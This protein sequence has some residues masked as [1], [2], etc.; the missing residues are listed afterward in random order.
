MKIQKC[1][2]VFCVE[3]KEADDHYNLTKSIKMFTPGSILKSK[4]NEKSDYRGDSIVIAMI[5][6]CNHRWNII[7]SF[8]KGNT[9]INTKICED[10]EVKVKTKQEEYL[11]YLNSE[12]WKKKAARKRKS[13]D[14][15]CQLCNNGKKT[16]HV[17]HRSYENV[18]HE[19]MRD[20]IVLCEDCH[21]R[22][23]S[24]T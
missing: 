11:D 21:N 7:F 13:A 3:H 8:H 6:E 15:K 23:H 20:L 24:T 18:Y 5:G 22:F 16:L 19:R 10:A 1:S 12:K 2:K 14:N 9:Y 4:I 17:H